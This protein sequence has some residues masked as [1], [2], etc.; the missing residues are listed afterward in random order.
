MNISVV[1]LGKL[2][3][4]LMAVLA[5]EHEVIGVDLNAR[6]VHD[7]N[8]CKAPFVEPGLQELLMENREHYTATTDTFEVAKTNMTFVVVPTPSNAD[9]EFINDHIF[10]AIDMM[11]A[12]LARKSGPH[13]V[14]ITST[15][16]P[17]STRGPIRNRLELASGRSDIAL[18]YCPEF[19]ALGSVIEDMQ[20]PDMFLVGSEDAWVQ[21]TIIDVLDPDGLVPVARVSTMEAEIAKLAV[22]AY[23]TTKISFANTIGEACDRL[24]VDAEKVTAAIGLDTRIGPKYLKP[25]GGYGGPCFPRDN[26]AFIA[27]AKNA[28]ISR[29]TVEVNDR[30][31]QRT[32]NRICRLAPETDGI[33]VLGMAY[34]PDTPIIERSFG[35]ELARTLLDLFPVTVYDP[36]AMDLVREEL[37]ASVKYA[38]NAQEAVEASPFVVIAQPCDEFRNLQFGNRK[39]LDLWG[40]T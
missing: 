16:M 8:E 38:E 25:A 29:G 1:G 13:I 35:V 9:G 2:G 32:V 12:A 22:N 31:V 21:A 27:W 17:G 33:T 39:V 30:Q 34:K 20:H 14:V 6:I 24:D 28:P 11:G 15:V 37:G 10:Q 19:I 40:I 26:E 3:S 23:V 7:I 4:C 18:A 5:S 36:L